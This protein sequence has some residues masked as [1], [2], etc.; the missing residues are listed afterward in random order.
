MNKL[1]AHAA[2]AVGIIASPAV[3]AAEGT[4]TLA[5]QHVLRGMSLDRQKQPRSRPRRCQGCRVL[6]RQDG[7]CHL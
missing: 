3:M 1:L 7:N 4:I 2:F 6:Q 5:E